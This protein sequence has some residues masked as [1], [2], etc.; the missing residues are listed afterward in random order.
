MSLE[1]PFFIFLSISSEV[2]TVAER[3][4]SRILSGMDPA[5]AWNEVSVDLVRCAKVNLSTEIFELNERIET[6]CV[7]QLQE[8]QCHT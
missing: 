8:L 6:G 3:L 1:I 7:L 4:Q 5:D 2:M